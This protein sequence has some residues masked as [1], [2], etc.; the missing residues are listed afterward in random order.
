MVQIPQRACADSCG[1]SSLSPL[2]P[3][4][5][6]FS[7]PPSSQHLLSPSFLSVSLP[8]LP[9]FWNTHCQG[10]AASPCPSHYGG[11]MESGLNSPP[12]LPNSIHH[13]LRTKAPLSRQT[14]S[15]TRGSSGPEEPLFTPLPT[16]CFLRE[17]DSP[18]SF[19]Y[20]KCSL[21][22]PGPRNFNP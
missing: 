7:L 15:R 6:T 4:S 12:P 9:G 22:G 1:F 13:V 3:P 11:W 21:S 14:D 19:V 10:H 18:V 5:V 2:T 8:S 16:H 17:L 20:Q